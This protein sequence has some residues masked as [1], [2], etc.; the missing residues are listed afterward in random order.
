MVIYF[1]IDNFPWI[2]SSALR[3]AKIR[4]KSLR[5]A[6]IRPNSIIEFNLNFIYQLMAISSAI[7]IIHCIKTTSYTHT[8]SHHGKNQKDN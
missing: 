6:K 4:P 8:P 7:N 1:T 3:F 2:N 5:F